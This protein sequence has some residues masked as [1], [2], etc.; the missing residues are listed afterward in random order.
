VRSESLLVLAVST[1][2]ACGDNTSAPVDIAWSATDSMV[3]SRLQ[4]S[5]SV[6]DDGRVL[7]AGGRDGVE[8]F[9]VLATAELLDPTAGSW[10]VAPAMNTARFQHAA[11]PLG[12]AVIVIGGGTDTSEIFSAA[13][14]SWSSASAMAFARSGHAAAALLDGRI[15][16]AG[17]TDDSGS[18]SAAEIYDPLADEWTMAAPMQQP[19][20]NAVAVT[21][22]DGSVL[23]VGEPGA[24]IYDPSTDRWR[25]TSAIPASPTEGHA[26][27]R[28]GTGRV[29]VAGGRSGETHLSALS[30]YDPASDAWESREMVQARAFARAEKD[31]DGDVLIIGGCDPLH[32]FGFVERV[33]EAEIRLAPAMARARCAHATGRLE[34]G[35]ILAAGGVHE[36][37]D[38]LP[39]AEILGPAL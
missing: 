36:A 32:A 21:L 38:P 18:L 28:L 17:G 7:I 3:G 29:V 9:E 25:S 22:D 2:L 34:D 16:V 39:T 35:R 37:G 8:N 30:I 12:D 19:R 11:M 27:A 10:M 5:A 4:H 14:E 31:S 33:T 26:M 1:L 15:L 20:A 24:E 13:S 23:V 6:L